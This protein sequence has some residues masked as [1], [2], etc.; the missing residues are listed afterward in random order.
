[1]SELYLLLTEY[2]TAIDQQRLT[3]HIVGVRTGQIRDAGRDVFRFGKTTE[4]N[5]FLQIPRVPA[6]RFARCFGNL[7]VNFRPH[8]VLTIPGQ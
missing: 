7:T 1:M 5:A 3:G 8:G 2:H 6:Q 4:G